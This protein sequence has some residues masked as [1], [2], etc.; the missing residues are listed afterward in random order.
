MQLTSI[1]LPVETSVELDAQDLLDQQDTQIM[2]RLELAASRPAGSRTSSGPIGTSWE[3]AEAWSKRAASLAR[4]CYPAG[5][6][7]FSGVEG[8]GGTANK[9]IRIYHNAPQGVS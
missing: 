3:D 1:A 6:F 8:T 9:R 7:R 4:T 2:E 5:T